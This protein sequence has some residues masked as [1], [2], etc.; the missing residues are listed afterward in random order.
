VENVNKSNS[1]KEIEFVTKKPSLKKTTKTDGFI[2][3][4]YSIPFHSI[5]TKQTN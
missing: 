3:E 5:I 2:G 1:I 4:F